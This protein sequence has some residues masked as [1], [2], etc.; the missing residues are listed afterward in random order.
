[1]RR[2]ITNP[3]SGSQTLKRMFNITLAMVDPPP[4]IPIPILMYSTIYSRVSLI[5]QRFKANWQQR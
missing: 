5:R 4:P 1:M 2:L 3:V